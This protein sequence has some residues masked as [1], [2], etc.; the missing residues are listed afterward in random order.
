MV[1]K[2]YPKIVRVSFACI[3]LKGVQ[4][5]AKHPLSLGGYKFCV[6]GNFEVGYGHP[7]PFVL[8]SIVFEIV[9]SASICVGICSG[10]HCSPPY[11]SPL[12]PPLSLSICTSPQP[13]IGMDAMSATIL[14]LDTVGG[15][16]KRI[17]HDGRMV[18]A[19]YHRCQSFVFCMT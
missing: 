10:A 8:M 7:H 3:W 18:S 15:C 11:T 19:S 17:P 14:P 5:L 9:R 4:I 1:L 13:F 12:H 16:H 6:G 2:L